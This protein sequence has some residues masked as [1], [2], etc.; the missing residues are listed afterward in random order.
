MGACS[1]L[2]WDDQCRQKKGMGNQLCEFTI[3]IILKKGLPQFRIDLMTYDDDEDFPLAFLASPCPF[4]SYLGAFCSWLLK[5]FDGS[6]T[7]RPLAPPIVP[8]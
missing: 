2:L 7:G 8:G 1:F 4:P 5:E 6:P 3:W